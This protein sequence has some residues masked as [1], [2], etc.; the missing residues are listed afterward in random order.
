[1]SNDI[2]YDKKVVD[3]WLNNEHVT[4]RDG[5][6]SVLRDV[7]NDDPDVAELKDIAHVAVFLFDHIVAQGKALEEAYE[8]IRDVNERVTRLRVDLDDVPANLRRE[9]VRKQGK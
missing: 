7:L 5:L 9:V 1:M 3:H 4:L 2:T 8:Q 6:Q